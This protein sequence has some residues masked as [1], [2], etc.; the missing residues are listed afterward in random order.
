[1]TG[2]CSTTKIRTYSKDTWHLLP[3]SSEYENFRR[4]KE[5]GRR[6]GA[7]DAR[8]GVDGRCSKALVGAMEWTADA[9]ELM[10][11][12]RETIYGKRLVL[13][14]CNVDRLFGRNCSQGDR[15]ESLRQEAI[16]LYA[17]YHVGPGWLR[18]PSTLLI[19]S[20]ILIYI[21]LSPCCFRVTPT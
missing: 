4:L 12:K 16:M 21:I 2:R 20:C 1:M 7:D 11:K 3:L 9:E 5:R 17:P 14:Q 19:K 13:L 10:R 8:F 18:S 6:N 15:N